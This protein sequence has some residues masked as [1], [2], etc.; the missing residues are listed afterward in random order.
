MQQIYARRD[1]TTSHI[2]IVGHGGMTLEEL[3]VPFIHIE[4]RHL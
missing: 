1:R 2:D 3:I 4:P